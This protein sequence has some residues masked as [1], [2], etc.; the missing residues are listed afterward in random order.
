MQKSLIWIFFI[1]P[2]WSAA[3]QQGVS[4]VH[5]LSWQQILQRA[6]SEN[7]YVFVDCYA[8]W[9][10]P[11][12]IM[13]KKVYPNDSVGTYMND[14]FISVRVQM[15]TTKE[16]NEEIGSW[17]GTAHSI[18]EQ[19][20]IRACP[21]YLFF[22][23]NGQAVH[24]NLGGMSI[25]DFLSMAKAA[26]NPQQQY[27]TLLTHYRQ[28]N[29]NYSLMPILAEAAARV[30]EDGLSTEVAGDYVHHYLETLPAAEAWTRDNIIFVNHHS[31]VVA[32]QDKVF[33]S[34]FQH[35]AIID[36]ISNSILNDPRFADH[37][38]NV[39]VYRDQIKPVINQSLQAGTEPN[40]NRLKN[41]ITHGCNAYYAGS[42]VLRGRVEYYK[43]SKK[44]TS[45]VK[46]YIRQQEE[47]GIDHWQPTGI[48]AIYLNNAAFEVFQYGHNRRE[49]KRAL[50]WANRALSGADKLHPEAMDTKANILYRLGKTEEGLVLEGKTYALSPRNADIKANY[51]K[52]KHGLPTWITE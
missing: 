39:I 26:L 6:R 19:Y 45:Y 46:W 42:N 5:N 38:I 14:Q 13:D 18:G 51:E 40:W 25:T 9:C 52:M 34:Y 7:K 12:K 47:E 44:W 11:C 33:C 17:Y 36:S 8:T 23:P 2:L 27:Y 35:R 10:G 37:L 22:S 15:D 16:D 50:V 28:G 30:G 3:Q 49:L 31:K 4:F 43:S 21:S 48:K 24:K 1:I 41:A 32:Y 20:H 29:L